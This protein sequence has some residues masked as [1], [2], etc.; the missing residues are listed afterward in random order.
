VGTDIVDSYFPVP[1]PPHMTF[2][3]QSM[4]ADWPAEMQGSYDLVHSRLALPG[5]GTFAPHGVVKRLVDLVKPGGYIQQVEMVFTQWPDSGP[6][7]KEFHQASVDVFGIA[8]GGQDLHYMKAI[9]GWYEEWGLEDIHYEVYTIPIG[10]KAPNPRIQKISI[11]SFSATCQ[12]LTDTAKGE[13]LTITYS[14]ISI[15]LR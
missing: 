1:P 12:S 9:A 10:A 7:M 8:V 2:M 14:T 13:Y 6:A 4:T 15:T 3:H 5:A 11:E